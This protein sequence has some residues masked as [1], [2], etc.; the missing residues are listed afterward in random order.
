MVIDEIP[1]GHFFLGGRQYF[2]TSFATKMVTYGSNEIIY[3]ENL[4]K[5]S[6]IFFNE[7]IV[8]FLWAEAQWS[9]NHFNLHS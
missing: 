8:L 7:T 5:I 9:V 4:E 3:L 1:E 6:F 2:F